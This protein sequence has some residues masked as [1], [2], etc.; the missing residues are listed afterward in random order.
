M[1]R[2]ETVIQID[3]PL[4]KEA[5]LCFAQDNKQLTMNLFKVLNRGVENVHK[6]D[7]VSINVLLAIYKS[8]EIRSTLL[9]LGINSLSYVDLFPLWVMLK[10]AIGITKIYLEVQPAE[11]DE[12]PLTSLTTT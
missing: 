6:G 2:T 11:E 9:Q 10:D 7:K 1:P 4:H 3:H 12:P 8:S 5:W